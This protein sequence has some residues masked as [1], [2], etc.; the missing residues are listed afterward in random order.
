MSDF[1]EAYY[2]WWLMGKIEI[3]YQK[4]LSYMLSEEDKFAILKQ[5]KIGADIPII[6]KG[7]E[8]T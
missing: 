7:K 8:N 6:I 3:H 4:H 5:Q 1:K 2:H